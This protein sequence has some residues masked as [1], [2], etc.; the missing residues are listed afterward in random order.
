MYEYF[1]ESKFSG[2]RV[3]VESDWSNYSTKRDLKHATGVDISKFAK[4][5]DLAN[6]KRDIDKLDIDKLKNVTTNSRN[7]ESKVDKL[8]V[9]KLVPVPVDL[10][11]LGDLV[12]TDVVKKVYIM[13]R[14][15][16]LKII[17]L[18]L[19]T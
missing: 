3:K 19:L 10:S 7:L 18:M 11:K 1:S 17:Y 2:G 13:L 9:G 16:I 15:E 8:D 5:V 14:S 12:K 4:N 6:I